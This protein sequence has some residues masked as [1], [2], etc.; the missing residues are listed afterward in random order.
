MILVLSA[1][2]EN[3]E[4]MSAMTL[5]AVSNMGTKL[6]DVS[7]GAQIKSMRES[8]QSAFTRLVRIVMTIIPKTGNV[9]I[10][11]SI[12]GESD[13]LEE[14]RDNDIGHREKRKDQV[15]PDDMTDGEDDTV[16]QMTKY[17]RWQIEV[18][19]ISNALKGNDD[20]NKSHPISPLLQNP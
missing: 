2:V 5:A 18:D 10:Q 8:F 6:S 19:T 16:P 15:H 9:E 12:S 3:L 7:T 13:L 1:K 11:E 4:L 20:H 17:P 14:D